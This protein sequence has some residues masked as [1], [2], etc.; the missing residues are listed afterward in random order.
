MV[1]FCVGIF[2]LIYFQSAKQERRL[3]ASLPHFKLQPL[4]KNQSLSLSE[5][6]FLRKVCM[7]TRWDCVGLR[8]SNKSQ[9]FKLI[10]NTVVIPITH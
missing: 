8:L 2:T 6:R 9:S 10:V 1:F 5:S 3:F 7:R 4:V